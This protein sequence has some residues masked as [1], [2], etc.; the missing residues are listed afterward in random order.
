MRNCCI[1]TTC[2]F[3]AAQAECKHAMAVTLIMVSLMVHWTCRCNGF[4]C[5]PSLL[6]NQCGGLHVHC[7]GERN[8][9]HGSAAG[10]FSLARSPAGMQLQHDQASSRSS[11]SKPFTLKL[12][13]RI[14]CTCD[15]C[16][17]PAVSKCWC[18]VSVDTYVY[19]VRDVEDHRKVVTCRLPYQEL[20]DGGSEARAG[21]W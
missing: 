17:R 2:Y 9:M 14:S 20:G 18:D 7:S 15:S 19:Y 16:T 4:L 6:I 13:I 5:G 3:G 11:R 10:A 21:D 1:T 8:G 12:Q